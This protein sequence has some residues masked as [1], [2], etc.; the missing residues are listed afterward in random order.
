MFVLRSMFLGAFFYVY[1]FF[2]M[3]M[4]RS[5]SLSTPCHVHV[6]DLHVGCYA[7]CFYSHF[8][9]LLYL[10]L[11]FWPFRQGVDLDLIVQAYVHKPRPISRIWIISPYTCVCLI[12][13][14]LYIHVCLS[15]FRYYHAWHPP[16][17]C[18]CRS[19][20]PL[21][22]SLHVLKERIFFFK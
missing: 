15:R 7:M 12:A 5:I 13:S 6:L 19:L 1:V 3:F 21:M 2:S 17:A 9:L 20:G 4:P 16:W 8:C 22:I 11:V 18:V 10:F 14:I